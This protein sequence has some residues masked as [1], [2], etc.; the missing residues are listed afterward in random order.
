LES[1]LLL[2]STEGTYYVV[3]SK[4]EKYIK[5]ETILI[6]E[7][8]AKKRNGT[9][10]AMEHGQNIENTDCYLA[11]RQQKTSRQSYGIIDNM[12]T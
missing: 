12:V 3:L 1:V 4:K 2:K 5:I 6:A 11:W 8:R 7:G 9:R 10:A